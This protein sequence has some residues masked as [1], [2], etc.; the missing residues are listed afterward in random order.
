M[1]APKLSEA[2]RR[3]YIDT[4]RRMQPIEELERKAR[5]ANRRGWKRTFAGIEGA[6]LSLAKSYRWDFRHGEE[7]RA[8][9]SLSAWNTHFCGLCHQFGKGWNAET[10]TYAEPV[11]HTLRCSMNPVD[12]GPYPGWAAAGRQALKET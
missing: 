8:A 9:A 10:K 3:A 12:D 6:D 5:K 11:K 2:Q 4:S 7:M 1:T